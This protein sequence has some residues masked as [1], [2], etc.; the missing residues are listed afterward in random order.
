SDVVWETKPKKRSRW[1]VLSGKEAMM[2]EQRYRDYM[3]SGPVDSIII[4]LENDYQ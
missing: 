2:L 4:D 3:E 1:K